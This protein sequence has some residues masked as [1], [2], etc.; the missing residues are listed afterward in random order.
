MK[1]STLFFTF[2]ALMVIT[3]KVFASNVSNSSNDWTNSTITN[4]TVNGVSDINTTIYSN[5]SKANIYNT[6]ILSSSIANEVQL[7]SKIYVISEASSCIS[8]I[9]PQTTI[10]QFKKNFNITD[11]IKVYDDKE[12]TKE[13]T[14]GYVGT[15]MYLKYSANPNPYVL[16]VIT[17]FNKDSIGNQIELNRIIK[18]VIG[19]KGYELSGIYF[20]SADLSFDGKVDQVDITRLIRYIVFGTLDINTF[21]KPK[22]PNVE[23]IDGANG[24]DEW[25]R[26]NVTIKITRSLLELLDSLKVTYEISGTKTVDETE[27]PKDSLIVL[28]EE[29]EYTITAFVYSLDGQRS[30]G[31]SKTIKIDKTAPNSGSLNMKINSNSGEEYFND[32]WTKENVYISLN[33]GS[34]SYSGHYKTTYEIRG[35]NAMPKGST[36]PKLLTESGTST[37]IIST[38]DYAGNI[39]TKSYIVKI[40]RG[41]PNNPIVTVVNGTKNSNNNEWYTSNVTLKVDRGHFSEELGIS[42]TTYTITGI[43]GEIE[44]SNGGTISITEDGIYDVVVYNYDRAGNRSS[45]TKTTIKKDVIAPVITSFINTDIKSTEFTVDVTASDTTSGI[46]KYDFYVDNT[47]YK[48][49]TTSLETA[50][51]VISGQTSDIHTVYVVVSDSAEHTTKSQNIEI[52]TER[53]ELTDI[54]YIEFVLNEFNSLDN[55]NS[56]AT[57]SNYVISDTSLT[58]ANK[59]IQVSSKNIDVTASIAGFVRLVRTDGTKVINLDYFPENMTF[60]MY[61]Y[62]YGSGTTWSHTSKA[63]FFK[64][65]LTG[66]NTEGT[67]TN[68]S[69][70]T[71]GKQPSDNNFNISD[72]KQSGVKTYTRVVINS[73]EY[74]STTL[75]FRIVNE[76]H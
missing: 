8:R 64:Q 19:V 39:A 52:K 69:I 14:T 4:S 9:V 13:V 53:L 54:S 47:L 51:C 1:K 66:T 20:L 12:C 75:P 16:S 60:N 72:L 7:T 74:N 43:N 67:K 59:Y 32:T 71:S 42:K 38:E 56:P 57:G 36:D 48:T 2:L 63:K 73:V 35:V 65:D 25:Y 3:P 15:G 23:V 24:I 44:I 18:H 62:L 5:D 70:S 11:N 55:S 45:G 61:H 34:D 33:D 41:E 46:L 37:I 6:D 30:A 27:V 31:T 49:I 40:Y 76:I 10:D 21:G 50:T 28:N 22:A 17:D 26:S 68:S 29:G 58:K